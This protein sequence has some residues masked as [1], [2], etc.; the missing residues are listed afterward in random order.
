MNRFRVPAGVLMVAA[1]HGLFAAPPAAPEELSLPAR[2]RAEMT[3]VNAEVDPR[4]GATRKAVGDML[5]VTKPTGPTTPWVQFP[6]TSAI[7]SITIR[8]WSLEDEQEALRA[9]IESGG[10]AAVIK[11]MKKLPT[12]GDVH[13]NAGRLSIRAAATWMTEHTQRIRLVVSGRLV[14]TNPDPFAQ[15]SRVLDILDLSLPHGERYGTGTLVTATQVEFEKPGLISPV[16]FA[17]DSATQPLSRVERQ[18]PEAR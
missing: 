4:T 10:L 6:T 3:I 12:L 2:L 14:T 5:G 18:P 15:S 16:V 11:T 8:R 13:V 9:A 17:I 1:I 7:V